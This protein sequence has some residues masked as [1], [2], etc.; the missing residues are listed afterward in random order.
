LSIKEYEELLERAE[1]SDDVAWLKRARRKPMRYRALIVIATSLSFVDV[2]LR[3][4][5]FL[6][7]FD[8][9]QKDNRP[10]HIENVN[11]SGLAWI[12]LVFRQSRASSFLPN[13]MLFS[14][15]REPITMLFE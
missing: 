2:I 11:N 12:V 15:D 3:N 10:E 8:P 4:P 1:D 7:S 5:V 6:L 9:A 14:S 13:A